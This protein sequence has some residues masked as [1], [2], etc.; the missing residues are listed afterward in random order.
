VQAAQMQGVV[1]VLVDLE[2]AQGFLLQPELAIRLPWVRV[3]L[4]ELVLVVL[5]A[6]VLFFL[7]LLLLAVV[8]V[9]IKL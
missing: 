5:K 1:A 6:P 7:P 4:A 8:L 3:V 2:P 9:G